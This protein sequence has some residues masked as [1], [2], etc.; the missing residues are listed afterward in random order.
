MRRK[1][2]IDAKKKMTGANLAG[3][4]KKLLENEV[5]ISNQ[6]NKLET[7]DMEMKEILKRRNILKPILMKEEEGVGMEE[8][9]GEEREEILE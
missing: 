4:N 2:K 7:I 5:K 6:Q 9:M 8:E 1:E 3:L